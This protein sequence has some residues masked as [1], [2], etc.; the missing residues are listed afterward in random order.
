MNYKDKIYRQ[1]VNGKF[2]KKIYPN[3]SKKNINVKYRTLSLDPDRG[4]RDNNCGSSKENQI[5]RKINRDINT[6]MQRINEN[7]YNIQS[8]KHLNQTDDSI[9][10]VT[11][12]DVV[13]S[14]EKLE[15]IVSEISNKLKIIAN[16]G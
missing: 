11:I 3:V 12:N 16:Q 1:Y 6:N 13:E 5:Q 14:V 8:D 10:M 15:K 2:G 4:D 9:K 7:N